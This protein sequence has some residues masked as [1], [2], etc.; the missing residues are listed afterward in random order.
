VSRHKRNHSAEALLLDLGL[1]PRALSLERT[2]ALRTQWRQVF[3]RPLHRAEGVWSLG[4]FEW[5]AFSYEEDFSLSG[6]K[7]RAAYLETGAGPRIVLPNADDDAACLVTCSAPFDLGASD[8]CV[9][10]ESLEWTMAFTHED[11]WLGPYFCLAKW[12]D[13]APPKPDPAPTPK[14]KRQRRGSRR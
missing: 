13:A 14:H 5:H 10:P 4:D 6:E 12:I 1:Q 9:F 3:A 2:A 11:G 8:F 7:A